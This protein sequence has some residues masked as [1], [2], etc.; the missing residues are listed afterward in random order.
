MPRVDIEMLSQPKC[1]GGVGLIPYTRQVQCLP[2]KMVI[3]AMERREEVHPLQVILR[4]LFKAL[5][6]KKWALTTFLGL[7]TNATHCHLQPLT[8]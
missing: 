1:K 2:T 8:F 4:V 6:L 3:F 7:L 5:S